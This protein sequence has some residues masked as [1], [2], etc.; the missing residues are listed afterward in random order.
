MDRLTSL[1][2]F[3]LIV[4]TGT[5]S[6]AAARMHLSPAMVT[7]HISKLE[8]R[9]GVRLLN[10]TTRRVDLTEEGRQ[11]LEHARTVLDA[12]S[13][14]ENAV[15][16]GSGRLVGRVHIDAPASVG[17]A[18]I[19]PALAALRQQHPDII[20]DL[21]LGDRG[22]VFR[23][24]GYDILL[25][26]G[27]APYASWFLHP[28]GVTRLLCFASPDYLAGHGIPQSPEDLSD[29]RC[30]LYASG[31]AAGGS[32]WAFAQEGR[33]IR[34]RPPAS[35]TFNDGAAIMAAAR[36]GLGIAQNM[37]MLARD[38]LRRGEL[39]PVLE[40]WTAA[41]VPVTLMCAKDRHQLPH[42]KA[43]MEFLAE[44]IDWGVELK[45]LSPRASQG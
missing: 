32:P 11:F 41:P 14:A 18:F 9:L 43:V 25:R 36:A 16:P 33:Q 15:R 28:L 23:T 35:F 37:E 40:A 22:T 44:Q 30:L 24:D 10:R 42:V 6:R 21:S 2:A 26:V 12:M 29:H 17:H 5:F 31:E 39:A 34:I 45:R 4:E 1:E 19:V 8:D 7:A 20:I 38:P 13:T 27:E 3:V